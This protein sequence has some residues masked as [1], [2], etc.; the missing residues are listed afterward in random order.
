MPTIYYIYMFVLLYFFVWPLYCLSFDLRILITPLVSSNFLNN[1]MSQAKRLEELLVE[2]ECLT[3]PGHP[4]PPP[5]PPG[6]FRRF[7]VARSLVFCVVFCRSFIFLLSF[8][9]YPLY[10]L[11]SDYPSAIL[12]HFLILY[13]V[14]SSY[15]YS[16]NLLLY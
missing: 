3:I 8:V 1:I 11:S 4:N 7:R 10:C 2:Q 12:K 6:F 9:F 15:S 16:K 13:Y 14:F 5:P